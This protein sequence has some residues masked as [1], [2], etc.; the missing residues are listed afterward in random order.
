MPDTWFLQVVCLCVMMVSHDV[1]CA[2]VSHGV[3]MCLTVSLFSHGV[4][5][6]VSQGISWYLIVVHLCIV[7]FPKMDCTQHPLLD[8]LKAC[9]ESSNYK[10]IS[11]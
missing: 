10:S 9:S 7:D 3:S 8:D 6:Y 5:W 2:L 4:S 1:K 11:K